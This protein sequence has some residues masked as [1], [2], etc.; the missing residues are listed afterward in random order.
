[1]E[2]QSQFVVL[3]VLEVDVLEGRDRSDGRVVADA[4]RGDS[5]IKYAKDVNNVV[6]FTKEYICK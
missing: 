4:H 6:I 2:V 5:E 1:M 3:L